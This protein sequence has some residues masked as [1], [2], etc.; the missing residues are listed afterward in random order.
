MKRLRAKIIYESNILRETV[1]LSCDF[2]MLLKHCCI[3]MSTFMKYNW[4][5]EVYIG[6]KTEGWVDQTNLQLK[7]QTC[8]SV[9]FRLVN[10]WIFRQSYTFQ[11]LSHSWQL[12]NFGSNVGL[13]VRF[14]CVLRSLDVVVTLDIVEV[15][16]LF[17]LL[18][19]N[20]FEY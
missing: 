16:Y 15:W 9:T 20:F 7:Q 14:E 10:L 17:L 2:R 4:N 19:C 12:S 8:I 13:M 11:L 5:S 1:V 6:H 3:K 18:N